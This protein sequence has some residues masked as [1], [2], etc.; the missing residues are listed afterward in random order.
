MRVV[1]HGGDCGL[2]AVPLRSLVGAGMGTQVLA[3][4]RTIS[5]LRWF[6]VSLTEIWA[7]DILLTEVRQIVHTAVGLNTG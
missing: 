5:C 2:H 1:P 3:S 4:T 7:Y 6:R